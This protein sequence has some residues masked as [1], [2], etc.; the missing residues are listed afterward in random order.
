MTMYLLYYVAIGTAKK[1]KMRKRSDNVLVKLCSHWYCKE[2]KGETDRTMS[3]TYEAI[4]TV[5]REKRKKGYWY[6]S[7]GRGVRSSGC[8]D[9]VLF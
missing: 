6:S 9:C 1:R 5:E 8:D 4:G 3:L 2:G 7:M